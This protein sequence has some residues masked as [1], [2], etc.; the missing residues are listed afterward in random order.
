MKTH[1]V[2]QQYQAWMDLVLDSENVARTLFAGADGIDYAEH[3][4]AIDAYPSPAVYTFNY[5]GRPT[6]IGLRG[7]AALAAVKSLGA[8]HQKDP[9]LL[10]WMYGPIAHDGPLA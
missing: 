5:Q 9:G 2:E 7:Y 8:D 4:G 3:I 6:F 1:S 10:E